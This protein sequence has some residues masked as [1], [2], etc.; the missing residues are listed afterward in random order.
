MKFSALSLILLLAP[1]SALA[2]GPDA[3]GVV[4]APASK[5]EAVSSAYEPC[6]EPTKM[7]R[8]ACLKKLGTSL[9]YHGRWIDSSVSNAERP[10]SSNRAAVPSQK[11]LVKPDDARRVENNDKPV[12]PVKPVKPVT[13][14]WADTPEK[15]VKIIKPRKPVKIIKMTDRDTPPSARHKPGLDF[16]G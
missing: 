3:G 15:P 2:A 6:N 5:A 8:A 9:L 1:G 16:K 7:A 4:L 11:T 14:Q 12:S 10:A 13:G